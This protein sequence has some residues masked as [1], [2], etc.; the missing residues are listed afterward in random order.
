MNEDKDGWL[1]TF[2]GEAI[3]FLALLPASGN[4]VAKEDK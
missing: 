2:G 3:H 1:S 4:A